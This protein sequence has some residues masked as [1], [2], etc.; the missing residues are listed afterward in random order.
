M[1]DDALVHAED[2][3]ETRS[4]DELETI[5]EAVGFRLESGIRQLRDRAAQWE[6][7]ASR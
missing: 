6:P 1:N 5:A 7:R 4:F 2:L 3:D